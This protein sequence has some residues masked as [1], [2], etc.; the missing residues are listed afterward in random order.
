[1]NAADVDA[2]DTVL[3]VYVTATES[4][5][6]AARVPG[7]VVRVAA[8]RAAVLSSE[9][10]DGAQDLNGDGDATDSVARLVDGATGAVTETG[11]AADAIALS[12]QVLCIA[13][14]ETAQGLSDLNGDGDLD[15]SVLFA[16]DIATAQQTNTGF[17]VNPE[18]LAAAGTHCV[19]ATPEI[20]E[21]P[22]ADLNGDGDLADDV[23]HVYD[24]ATAIG[25]ALPYATEDLV[26]QGD[27]VA[28]RVCEG[29]QGLEDLNFDGDVGA[30][31]FEC[32][33]H[34]LHL[35]SGIVENTERAADAC[36]LPG[37]DPFFEP[38]RVT[39]SAV[40]FL[41]TEFAQ[42]GLSVPVGT[43]LAVDC[44]AIAGQPG[45]CDLT[46]DGDN[47]DSMI[48]IYGVASRKAQLIPLLPPNAGPG[49]DVPPFPTE[50]GNSGVLYVQLLETQVGEDVNGD[51]QITDTPVLVLVSDVDG[52]GTLDDSVNRNDT[53]VEVANPDQVD[54]DRDQLGDDACDPAPT[55]SL[56]GDISCDVDSNGQIDRDDIDII[57]GDRGTVARSSD[58]RDADGDGQISV[59][60]SSAC[61]AQCTYA[62]CRTSPATNACGFGAELVLILGTIELARRRVRRRQ[63]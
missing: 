42:T 55:A 23:L 26:A 17:S 32:V 2:V 29:F 43:P 58:P 4:Y 34:V 19:F 12:A 37:C 5:R 25:T 38:Y 57:F 40:S 48:S 62:N 31:G 6:A 24:V 41:T 35:S 33:M 7:A 8:G 59:L 50:I 61:R 28:F 54:A 51:G 30:P 39:P 1:L 53:C 44:K 60:D 20:S 52:D 27:L 22:G 18:K 10:D 21:A 9:A 56:P 3:Q 49:Q 45:Y 14:N 16:R 11:L 15:D 46:G 13:M 47:N 36:R 63:S